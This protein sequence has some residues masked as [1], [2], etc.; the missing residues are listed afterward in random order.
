M[1]NKI[2][3]HDI[4]IQ[5]IIDAGCGVPEPTQPQE[6][7]K[8]KICGGNGCVACDARKTQ[9]QEEWEKD[10]L[11]WAERNRLTEKQISGNAEIIK[12][13]LISEK[14]RII[15]EVKDMLSNIVEL[16]EEYGH[17]EFHNGYSN[18]WDNCLKIMKRDLDELIKNI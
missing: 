11:M 4:E 8:C 10:Y 2:T 3:K 17:T 12:N 5:K 6:D 1:K 15:K 16:G 13:L 7:G 14:E 18:G 9:P